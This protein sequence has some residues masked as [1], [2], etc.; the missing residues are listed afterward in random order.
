MMRIRAEW[1]A[2]VD[3]W[4]SMLRLIKTAKQFGPLNVLFSVLGLLFSVGEYRLNVDSKEPP[5][6][7]TYYK[8]RRE[9]WKEKG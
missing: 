1:Y 5:K 6:L 7:G 8:Y 2:I 4:K 9:F 3:V